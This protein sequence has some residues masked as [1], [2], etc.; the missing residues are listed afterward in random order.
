MSDD[1]RPG[2]V[3][4]AILGYG[5]WQRHFGGD[6]GVIGRTV[7]INA[8]PFTVVGVVQPGFESFSYSVSVGLFV[9]GAYLRK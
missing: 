3:P 1:D 5:Y 6:P 4:T 9:S 8:K 2:A 7:I